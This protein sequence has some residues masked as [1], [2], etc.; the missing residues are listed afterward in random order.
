M[1]RFDHA[2]RVNVPDL[3]LRD[4][5]TYRLLSDPLGSPRLA[6]DTATGAVVQRIDYDEWGVVL[7][8]TNL[9]WQ[10]FGFAGGL[11]DADTGLV[12]FG[13]RDYDPVAG[14]WTSKDPIGFHG[15][16]ANLF[17]YLSSGPLNASDSNGLQGARP[18]RPPVEVPRAALVAQCE[19]LRIAQDR[20]E[21]LIDPYNQ[22]A[23]EE[24][25]P[26]RDLFPG[27][28]AALLSLE[29]CER[30]GLFAEDQLPSSQKDDRN[31]IE[32][33]LDLAME[34]VL[35]PAIG[36]GIDRTKW[37]WGPIVKR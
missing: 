34:Y 15:L 13:W 21:Q 20:G 24:G 2:T 29:E 33:S 36:W 22:L 32:R 7:L 8:D 14:R 3:I 37:A 26:P 16:Q 4:G 12:R 18:G 10:P 27:Q 23:C 6:I 17:T 5:T 9:G 25:E 19:A 31:S 35:L 28:G 30:L 1:S 11:Y